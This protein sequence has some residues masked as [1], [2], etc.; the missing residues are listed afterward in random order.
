ML[1]NWFWFADMF[2]MGFFGFEMFLAIFT[3]F[4]LMGNFWDSWTVTFIFMSVFIVDSRE[5]LCTVLTFDIAS[6]LGE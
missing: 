6:V 1:R 5:S 3:G 4:R 2:A